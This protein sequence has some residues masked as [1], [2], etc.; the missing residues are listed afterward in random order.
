VP[1]DSFYW[2]RDLIAEPAA[3]PK[4]SPIARHDVKLVAVAVAIAA[5]ATAGAAS[6]RVSTTSRCVP[7]A[8]DRTDPKLVQ[9]LGLAASPTGPWWVANEAK[10][11]STLYDGSGRKQALDVQVIGGPQGVVYYGG[12][13][14]VVRRAALRAGALPVRVRG[15]DD[16]CVEPGRP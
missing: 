12:R 5:L 7:V 10:A 14:F 4:P 2:Y 11:S 9:R 8:L 1:K 6:A 3:A 15:R 13:G 16:P